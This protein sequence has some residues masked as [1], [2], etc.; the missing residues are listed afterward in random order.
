MTSVSRSRPSRTT[1]RSLE[2]DLHETLRRFFEEDGSSASPTQ[3]WSPPLDVRET[4]EEYQIE[5]DLPGVSADDVTID[6]DD[7]Q[8]TVHGKRS[9]RRT[10]A[11]ETVIRRERSH[12]H[13]FR[14]ISLPHAARMEDASAEFTKGLLTI[15][16]PK[17]D[18]SSARS[19]PIS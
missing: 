8:L 13:F 6:A 14:R 9:T 10:S 4:D 3:T 12:G 1:L 16:V 7:N 2:R 11:T 19:I 17:T 5:M 15:R 18:T